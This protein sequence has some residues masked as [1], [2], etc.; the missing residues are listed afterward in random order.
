MRTTTN[1][2]IRN[3]LVTSG[4]ALPR[5]GAAAPARTSKYRPTGTNRPM[6]VDDVVAKS[7]VTL[8]TTVAA[9]VA[10]VLFDLY[11]AVLPAAAAGLGLW[12]FLTFRL[13]ASAGL[14]LA[15]ATAQGVVTGGVT[16]LLDGAHPGLAAQAALGT[17][18][19][20]VAMLAVYKLRLLRLTTRKVKWFIAAAVGVVLLL[21]T[22]VLGAAVLGAEPGLRGGGFFPIAFSLLCVCLAAFSFLLGFEAADRMIRHGVAADWAWYLAFGLVGTLLWLYTELLWLLWSFR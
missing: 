2:A 19:V 14:T 22:E 11:A 13:T 15:Y 21:L 6:T 7:A 5:A 9:G 3:L 10:T 8:G 17:T 12:L 4:T 1:P 18:G 16:G 20:F